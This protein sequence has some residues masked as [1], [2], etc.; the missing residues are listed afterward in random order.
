MG[1]YTSTLPD[2]VQEVDV[3]IAGG[4]TA[5]CIVASRLA[6]A[7]PNLVIL[8]IEH[9]AN[10]QGNPLITNP[11]LWRA[12]LA[13]ETGTAIYYL[14]KNES[15]LDNRSIAV[16]TGGVLG[17]GSSI[18]L[19]IYSRPQA[20]D[21]DAWKVKGWCADDLRPFTNKAETYHGD[22]P[23]GGH[24]HDGAIHVSK[25]P[26]RQLKSER[27]FISAMKQ[28]GYPEI[29]D[30]QDFRSNN[31][32][33]RAFKYVS[34]DGK[35]QDVAS[36]YLHPRLQGGNHPN[37]HV[38]LG[39]QV[40]K[41]LF[42][43][44]D[45]RAVGV[46]YRPNPALSEGAVRQV[47]EIRA[48]KLVVLSCGA[49]GTPGV[50]ERS[51]VGDP[52]VLNK[53]RIPLV[54]DIPGVGNGYQDHQVISYHYRVDVP[55]NETSDAPFVDRPDGIKKILVSND[56]VLGWNGFDSSAKIRPSEAEV[57]GLGS[58]YRR[59]WDRDYK[60]IPEK[61]LSTVILSTG[62]LGDPRT[63]PEDSYISLGV[64]NTYPYSRGHV[65]ITGPN[66][67]D[68]LDFE[69]GFLADE[70]NFDLTTHIWGYK[71]QREV[72]RRMNCYR[73]EVEGHIP[74]FPPGSKAAVATPL[75][76]PNAGDDINNLIEYGPDD[77]AAIGDWVRKNIT[78]CWHGL[79]TCKMAPLD[80]GDMGVVDEALNVHG[81]LALKIADLSIAPGNV[82]ANTNNT[83]LMIGEKAADIIIREL[84]L[85]A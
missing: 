39:S 18:N 7:D 35:R 3:I 50:L 34:A 84:S 14:A 22:D 42:D 26:F 2:N 49:L 73:G 5:G 13:P 75:T 27:D 48:R 69:T 1:L 23:D 47:N 74:S 11:L 66:F 20:V 41:V 81:T 68:P 80:G 6:D 72:A 71:K 54:A 55:K 61:P 40:I 60:A 70:H 64:Y 53:A 58:A 32:A 43:E 36:T 33:S 25:G 4:G 76:Q 44:K 10:N 21:Y 30:L 57:D 9:G 83:A 16:A 17:G 31:G 78:T 62:I 63:V 59:L 24:G 51:G 38:L 67:E 52:N 79:G 77:D 85:S 19:S 37:L 56:K 46:Q 12:N 8:L 65:H 29:A 15:Q 28:I 45:K 82:S